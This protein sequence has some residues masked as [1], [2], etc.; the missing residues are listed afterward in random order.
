MRTESNFFHDF[1]GGG[2]IEFSPITR[3]YGGFNLSFEIGLY[4]KCRVPLNYTYEL[5]AK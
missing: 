5:C 3:Y 4:L 2:Q 1:Q